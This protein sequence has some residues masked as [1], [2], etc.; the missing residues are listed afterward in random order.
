[1]GRLLC[2]MLCLAAAASSVGAADRPDPVAQA[3]SFYN[4]RHYEAAINAAERARLVPARADSADLVAARAYLERFRDSATSDDLANARLRLAR[5]D[6]QRFTPRER[7]E[8]IVGLGEALYF[9]ESYGASADVF[10]SALDAADGPAGDGRE[11]V[12]DW[13]AT[14]VDAL[15]R[16]RADIE[17]QGIYERVR[18]RMRAEIAGRSG[19]AAAAYWLAAAARGKGD[20]QAAWEAAEAGWV[21]SSLASDRGARLRADLDQLML[22]AVVPERARA[23]GQP[24]ENLRLEWDRFKERW[25]RE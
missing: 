24:P 12:L 18:D 14:A 21:R 3:R 5:L 8:F 23:L 9:E 4:Q 19:S 2:A 11:R 25:R 22:G 10:A 6:P 20:L 7:I 16:P 1:M 15:A 17:R 13:W